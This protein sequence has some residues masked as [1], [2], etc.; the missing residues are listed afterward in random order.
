[1]SG[2]YFKIN[3]AFVPVS[4]ASIFICALRTCSAPFCFLDFFLFIFSVLNHSDV[5]RVRSCQNGQ[6]ILNDSPAFDVHPSTSNKSF[7]TFE[8]KD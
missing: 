1:M 6:C 2:F 4:R 7:R 5:N 8:V 3:F